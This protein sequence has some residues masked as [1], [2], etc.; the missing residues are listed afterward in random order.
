MV[1]NYPISGCLGYAKTKYYSIKKPSLE[2][3]TPISLKG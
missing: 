2:N 3:M 1:K